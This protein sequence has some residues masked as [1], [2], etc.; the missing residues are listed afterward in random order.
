[1]S[2]AFSTALSNDS[3]LNGGVNTTAEPKINLLGLD[4]KAMQ[5]FFC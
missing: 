1:M 5:H 2:T 4:R 3:P